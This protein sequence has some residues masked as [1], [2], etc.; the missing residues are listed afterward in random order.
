MRT[1]S[2]FAAACLASACAG[3]QQPAGSRPPSI[4]SHDSTRPT[5]SSAPLSASDTELQRLAGSIV[6]GGHAYDYVRDLSD[7]YGPRL[8]GSAL[9]AAAARWAV[10]SFRRAGLEGAR[11]EEFTIPHGWERREARARM[12]S[13]VERPIHVSAVGWSSPMP[14]GGVRGRVMVLDLEDSMRLRESELRGAIV[15]FSTRAMVPDK[16]LARLRALK[17]LAQ[18]GVAAVLY[19][20]PKPNQGM[21]A[22][23]MQAREQPIPVPILDVSLEDGAAIERAAE[24]GP[25]TLELSN[26][27][28]LL[29]PVKVPNVV[30]DIRGSE[31]PDEIVLVGAHLD[32]WDFGTGAQDN[33]TG[34]ASVLEAARAIRALSGGARP[35][36]RT[37]RFAL[38]GGEEQGLLGSRAYAKA[39]AG[40]LDRIVMVLNTDLGSGPPKGWI[41]DGRPDVIQ[42]LSPLAK[43]WLSGLG[44]DTLQTEMSCQSDHCPFWVEGVPTLNLDVDSTHYFEVH[45]QSGDTLDKISPASL[46]SGAAVVAVTA[47]GIANLPE[48]IAP[49]LDHATVVAHAKEGKLF[50]MLVHDELMTE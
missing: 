23:A 11:I 40:E 7:A 48:R 44:A 27:S 14:A 9:L 49:R 43:S 3:P 47:L 31:H 12:L 37:L 4:D 22:H 50:E 24:K 39:H 2:I 28:P 1:L 18:A 34:V 45:H 35:P 41:A 32:A 10:E 29:G 26:P 30:A 33:G 6:V 5:M 19:H 13:P 46:A 20:L 38:W 25:V 17:T 42:R 15:V 16:R 36:K 21:L 8:T